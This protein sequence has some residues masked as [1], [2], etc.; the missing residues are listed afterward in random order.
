M[1]KLIM[2]AATITAALAISAPA[3][4]AQWG[5]GIDVV[6]NPATGEPCEDVTLYDADGVIT[7]FDPG[8]FETD[9]VDIEGGCTLGAM[10]GSSPMGVGS[11]W[12]TTNGAGA[13]HVDRYGTIY[14]EAPQ[15]EG[16]ICS[17]S[18]TCKDPSGTEK[19]AWIGLLFA[20]NGDIDAGVMACI[21][22]GQK[23][24]APIQ[25]H[26]AGSA[27]FEQYGPSQGVINGLMW[28]SSGGGTGIDIETTE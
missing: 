5:A 4:V 14:V 19:L 22:S 18:L 1:R 2:L 13:V 21:W 24:M 10:N 11:Y 9:A 27:L 25:A 8:S 7:G 23:N 17:S 28:N 3:A 15:L 12:C 26:Y 20:V 6:K 16:D